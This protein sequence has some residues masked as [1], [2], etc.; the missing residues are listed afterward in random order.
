MS[1]SFRTPLSASSVVCGGGGN[2]AVS[3]ERE[4]VWGMKGGKERTRKGGRADV[5]LQGMSG[6]VKT[7]HLRTATGGRRVG[8]DL[9]GF[10]VLGWG[11]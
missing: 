1:A 11:R 10:G 3:V 7:D 4:C 2:W 9:G 8:S 6:G 5:W